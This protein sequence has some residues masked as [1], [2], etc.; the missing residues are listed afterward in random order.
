L[1][2]NSVLYVVSYYSVLFND[3]ALYYAASAYWSRDPRLKLSSLSS[4]VTITRC[5]S[6]HLH[7]KIIH[8]ASRCTLYAA[9]G[10][11]IGRAHMYYGAGANEFDPKETYVIVALLPSCFGWYVPQDGPPGFKDYY[12][13]QT[14]RTFRMHVG[15]MM[16]SMRTQ[17]P[18]PLFSKCDDTRRRFAVGQTNH[19]TLRSST[20]CLSS[21]KS[22]L[23]STLTS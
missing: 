6:T 1:E 4:T 15:S 5:L 14:P 9:D 11:S 22:Q 17:D 3:V 7:R 13:R 23:L 2:A 18:S 16:E 8:H 21:I 12:K 20:N 19:P 10:E